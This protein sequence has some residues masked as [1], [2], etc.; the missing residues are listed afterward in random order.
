MR[1][2]AGDSADQLEE[3]AVEQ[4]AEDEDDAQPDAWNGWVVAFLLVLL[5]I[6]ASFFGLR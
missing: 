2:Y 6:F 5:L 4:A 1:A 3:G